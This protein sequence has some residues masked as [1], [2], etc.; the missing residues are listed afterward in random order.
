MFP[1]LHILVP[2]ISLITQVTQQALIKHDLLY[3][4]DQNKNP[5]SVILRKRNP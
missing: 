5:D 1:T 4:T 3:A 2:R